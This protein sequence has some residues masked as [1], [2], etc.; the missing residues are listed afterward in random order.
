MDNKL[1]NEEK[2][3]I[4]AMYLGCRVTVKPYDKEYHATLSGVFN[5]A[6]ILKVFA[7]TDGDSVPTHYHTEKHYSK[8]LLK[9]LAAINDEDAIFLQRAVSKDTEPINDFTAKVY[10]K[11][12]KNNHWYFINN[13]VCFQYLISKGYA[14]PLFFG[15]DNW[16]N[17][18]T[19]IDL[20]I[21]IKKQ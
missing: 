6:D 9:T 15:V 19:A 16:A 8:L 7:K 10:I 21:A 2:A 11:Y 12:I 18:K 4:Y 5:D 13:A 17:G 3:K 14:V 1:T 20:G